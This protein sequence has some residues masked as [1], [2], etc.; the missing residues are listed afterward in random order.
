[1]SRRKQGLVPK[2]TDGGEETEEIR[3]GEGLEQGGDSRC[4]YQLN[5]RCKVCCHSLKYV[6]LMT[7]WKRKS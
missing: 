5:V 1:M 4:C 2:K 3:N 7:F 6:N